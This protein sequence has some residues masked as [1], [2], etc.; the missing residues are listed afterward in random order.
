MAAA[1]VDSWEESTV[2]DEFYVQLGK[3]LDAAVNRGELLPCINNRAVRWGHIQVSESV[4]APLT[5]ADIRD[6]RL[7]DGDILV[8]EGGEI[9]RASVWSSELPEAYFLNTL[10]RLRSKGRFEPRLLVAFFE[11]LAATGEFSALVG[12]SSIAHLTK[13]NLQ[14]VRILLPAKA[15]QERMAEALLAVDKLGLGLE[16]LIAKKQAIKQGMMQQYMTGRVAPHGCSHLQWQKR[17]LGQLLLRPPRYGINAAAVPL[18]LGLSTYIRITDINDSGRF[19]PDPKV[20]VSHPS[21]ANYKLKPGELVLAR[22]GASVGKAYL[23]D[24]RDGEL[25]YAGFLIS[26]APDPKLLNPKFFAIYT[27]T[28]D[29]WDWVARTSVRSGQ[30]GINGREYAQLLLNLPDIETQEAIARI[31][32]DVDR[33]IE[34]LERR[35]AKVKNIKMGI[36]QQLLTG[37]THLPG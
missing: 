8:C 15:E 20:G 6:L 37:R 29:Y 11:R 5:K 21:A 13:E 4:M 16:Q 36:T 22:T 34:S 32:D 7:E 17:P 14:R 26:V 27:Q 33:D 28:K 25:V 9:G 24:P 35:L 18:S 1:K 30:P 2:G 31:F 23:Y 10:H 12:K 19:A 3:R